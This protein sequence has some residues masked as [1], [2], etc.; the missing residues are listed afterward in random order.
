[1]GKK[2]T[3]L[4]G[5]DGASENKP[6]GKKFSKPGRDGKVGYIEREVDKIDYEGYEVVRRELFS[7]ANCPAVTFKFGSVV[8]NVRAIRKL[9]ECGFVLFSMNK[10]KK[11]F[12]V[13]SC[14]ED[15]QGALQ[16]SRVDKRGKVV[17]RTIKGDQFT[18]QLYQDMKWNFESTMKVLG[19][20]VKCGGQKIFEFNLANAEAYLFLAK[21]FDDDPKRRKRVPFMPEHWRG[22]YGQ[23]YDEHKNQM[24]A[25]FE[26][27]PEGFVKIIIPP[28]QQPNKKNG[29]GDADEKSK[30]NK[31]GAK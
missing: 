4:F 17:P 28:P 8:F 23:P 9:D 3:D 6:G 5:D 29:H 30:G 20:L 26:G 16:W 2:Q 12:R 18:A 15:A 11:S 1:M 21:Q 13:E 7:K 22:N 25:T 19:T 14:D 24:V 27:V 31:N 10:G